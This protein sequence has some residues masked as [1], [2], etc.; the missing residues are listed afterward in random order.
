MLK[1]LF[2]IL[3]STAGTAILLPVYPFVALA[4]KIDSSG[5]VFYLQDRVGQHGRNF[6]IIKFRTMVA[7]ADRHGDITSSGDSRI[8]RFGSLLRRTKFDEMPTLIN[9]L[10]G[11]MSFV[12]PRPELP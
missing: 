11:D 10:K 2:D 1:R 5:S 8:T 3:T 12:G 9:V 4:I 6:R 7:G